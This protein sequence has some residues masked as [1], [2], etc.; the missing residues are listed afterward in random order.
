[1]ELRLAMFDW[2]KRCAFV[3]DA[4]LGVAAHS[5]GNDYAAFLVLLR[6]EVKACVYSD[7]LCVFVPGVAFVGF[8]SGFAGGLCA[9]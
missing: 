7:F 3:D 5:L 6:P 9:A 1:M 4:R 2:M 8:P